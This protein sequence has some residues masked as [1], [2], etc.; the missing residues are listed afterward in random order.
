MS[1]IDLPPDVFDALEAPEDER[2]SVL[3]R[4][5][6]VSLYR[7]GYLT[8]GKAR[9]ISGL[10]KYE[11]HRLLGERGVERH[12]TEADLEDDIEYARR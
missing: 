6:A 4:E 10:T 2:E 5:L 7:E 9:E 3:Y 1:G 8:F 11:F 12:C